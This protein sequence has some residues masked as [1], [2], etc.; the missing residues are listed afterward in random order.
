V[1]IAYISIDKYI[2]K[3]LDMKAVYH[4]VFLPVSTF[5]KKG[6]A[7]PLGKKMLL[8]SVWL[9]HARSISYSR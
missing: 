6:A 1:V 9:T 8:D 7:L 5:W 2:T 4:I 3:V